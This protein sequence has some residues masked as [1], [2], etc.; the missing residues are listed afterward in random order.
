[1]CV[2]KNAP[3]L[4]SHLWGFPLYLVKARTQA[5]ALLPKAVKLLIREFTSSVLMRPSG[6]F[7]SPLLTLVTSASVVPLFR[8]VYSRVGGSMTIYTL[9]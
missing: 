6:K 5:A 7:P 2:T 9:P 4:T 8:V 3:S 1:M